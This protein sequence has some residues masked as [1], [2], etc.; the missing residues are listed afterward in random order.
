MTQPAL[1]EKRFSSALI[2]MLFLLPWL[3]GFAVVFFQPT[4]DEQAAPIV[5]PAQQPDGKT[6]VLIIDS[7]RPQAVN[8]P[9]LMPFIHSLSQSWPT[10]DVTTCSAN[11]TLPCIQTLLEGRESPFVAGLHNFTGQAGSAASLPSNAKQAG[12]GVVLLSDHTLPSLYGEYV[13]RSHDVQD[14][15]GEHLEHDLRAIEVATGEFKSPDTDLLIFHIV[16]TDKVA[17]HQRPGT[18]AYSEHFQA[19]DNALRGLF[20][21]IDPAH[22]RVIITGDHGHDKLGNHNKDSVVIFYG[23]QLKHLFDAVDPGK[24]AQTDLLYFMSY[25]AMLPVPSNVDT[26]FFDLT[27]TDP[28]DAQFVKLHDTLNGQGSISKAF[29]A[30]KDER[31]QT[32]HHPALAYL[33]LLVLGACIAAWML[34]KARSPLGRNDTYF[35]LGVGVTAVALGYFANAST[36]PILA[37]V[38]LVERILW[39]MRN[40]A[41]RET[42]A[43][44]A[45]VAAASFTGAAAEPWSEF[46][47]TRGGFQPTMLLFWAMLIASGFALSTWLWK[48]RNLAP[49]AA[50]LFCVCALPSGVYYYHFGQNFYFGFM[51]TGVALFLSALAT[52]AGRSA[53]MGLVRDRRLRLA[54]VAMI[55]VVVYTLMQESGGWE[56]KFFPVRWFKRMGP[57]SW[58]AYAAFGITA[59]AFLRQN[60]HRA[61]LAVSWVVFP[62][63]AVLL[64]DLPSVRWIA[65]S[66]MTVGAAAYFTL[67]E[68]T[69][70]EA[71]ALFMIAACLHVGWL[72]I[73]G[74]L[75]NHVDFQFGLE[76]FGGLSR[77]VY[78]FALTQIATNFKYTLAFAPIVLI[79]RAVLT[80]E[81]FNIVIAFVLA[82]GFLKEIALFGHILFGRGFQAGKLYELAI[83]DLI[84][85]TLMVL[86]IPVYALPLRR[87]ASPSQRKS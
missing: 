13:I 83:S 28:Y 9:E 69:R 25:A 21:E 12:L 86:M 36:G 80:R 5:A 50:M 65:A 78:T 29:E 33:P 22:D 63:Y 84:F 16:G 11:F 66:V 81:K 44:L 56:W 37:L 17:H 24:I 48:D 82:F 51:L 57:W 15:P 68:K 70:E 85:V 53:L 32:Q 60:K 74:F 23:N 71:L 10:M 30:H 55:A 58:G 79:A 31:R 64:A 47:H 4:V 62:L 2:R 6:V 46:F 67:R 39:A 76:M 26:R 19:I 3:T 42:I 40:N 59:A 8:D 73:D 34:V 18:Q 52:K 61:A 38:I 7:L 14:W 20:A 35:L 43:A 77:E 75:L 1:P 41:M 45:L 87:L 27:P 54:L 49:E 72:Q